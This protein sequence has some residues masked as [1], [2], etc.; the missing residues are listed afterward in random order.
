MMASLT[1]AT[2]K[3]EDSLELTHRRTIFGESIEIEA[4]GLSPSATFTFT[5][6]PTDNILNAPLSL[7]LVTL[8]ILLGGVW[9][10]LS[11]TK[12][13]RRGAIWIELILIPVVLLALYLAYPPYTVGI[14]AAI[15]AT[16]WI[17]TAV[18]SPKRK[19]MTSELQS[20][21]Y[22]IIDCPACSTPNPITTDERPFRMPCGGCGRVLKIVE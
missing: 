1:G 15:A 6:M 7:S 20:V 11:I 10:S 5:A 8:L 17:I 16:I 2:I 9:L 14:I 4:T 18:A 21:N 22:P 13:K 19:G 12:N 3:G